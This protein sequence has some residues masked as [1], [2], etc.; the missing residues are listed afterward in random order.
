MSTEYAG[1]SPGRPCLCVT[2]CPTHPGARRGRRYSHVH[3]D[4]ALANPL[5]TSLRLLSTDGYV[6][7][8]RAGNDF[9]YLSIGNRDWKLVYISTLALLCGPNG[10]IQS[11]EDPNRLAPGVFFCFSC[12]S[13]QR[14]T[15]VAETIRAIF[16]EYDPRMRSYSLDEAYLNVTQALTNRL[17]GS[18]AAQLPPTSATVQTTDGAKQEGLRK[19]VHACG[20]ARPA[21]AVSD[22]EGLSVTEDASHRRRGEELGVTRVTTAGDDE[23]EEDEVAEQEGCGGG[24]GRLGGGSMEEHRTRLFEAA[25][26]MAEE[27]RGRIKEATK[28]T[29]S[30]GIGPNFMLAKV[31]V[32][33]RC[34]RMV[35]ARRLDVVCVQHLHG[36]MSVDGLVVSLLQGLFT[37]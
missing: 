13:I 23:E 14:Y 3:H 11:V 35:C 10:V 15:Q 4:F 2:D 1:R 31:R 29:A 7:I 24:G 28:L 16:R 8:H 22:G 30:V 26:R 20:Y 18:V 25:R 34:L 33:A 36:N 12:F 6:R 17:R 5:A 19:P 21:A 27:I 37:H 32:C 9:Q